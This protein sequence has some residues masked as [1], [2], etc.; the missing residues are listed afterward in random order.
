VHLFNGPDM[1]LPSEQMLAAGFHVSRTV[2][3]EAIVL[4]KG[5]GL[6]SRNTGATP[7]IQ[8]PSVEMLSQTI[9][10]MVKAKRIGSSDILCARMQIEL[11]AA[12]LTAELDEISEENFIRLNSLNEEMA[13]QKS[14]PEMRAELDLQFHL[15]LVSLCGNPLLTIFTDSLKPLLK[16][17]LVPTFTLPE[18]HEDGIRSHRSLLAKLR[19][20]TAFPEALRNHLLLSIRN[21]ESLKKVENE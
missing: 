1:K 21:Y 12:S 2:I 5:R 3:R 10:R 14:N 19:S 15:V 13:N 8:Q 20:R 7:R 18:V 17:L 6:I 16:P 11:S 4:L 9:Q